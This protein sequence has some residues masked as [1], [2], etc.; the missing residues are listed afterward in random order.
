MRFPR[1]TRRVPLNRLYRR[2]NRPR[3][4]VSPDPPGRSLLP[5]RRAG[6]TG[7][8]P[9]WWRPCWP[10]AGCARSWRARRT[11]SRGWARARRPSCANGVAGARA[12]GP[13]G[14]PPPVDHGRR[15]GRPAC[16][17][18]AR[19]RGP[20]IP[21][22]ELPRGA[23][24]GR[25]DRSAGA[26]G[27]GRRSPREGG[28]PCPARPARVS[29]A[30]QCVQAAEPLPAL[31]GAEGRRGPRAVVV[32]AA[33]K[34]VVPLDVHMLRIGRAFGTDPA[35]VGGLEGG[36]RNHGGVQDDL[37]GRSG[38]LRLRA[39]AGRMR[40]EIRPVARR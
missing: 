8:S 39:D 3:A 28:A 36:A 7:R 10:T 23:S 11:R 21:G 24:A 18:E 12:R 38:A 14:V 34:L 1:L 33:S 35:P 37:A 31:D 15:R 27:L 22:A 26:G 4:A 9:A 19:G 5:L 13:A 29:A 17:R 30:G 40:G 2:Y 20:R 25:R 16:W 6:A 32:G